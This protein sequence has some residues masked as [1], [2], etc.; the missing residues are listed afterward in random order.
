MTTTMPGFKVLP[1]IIPMTEPDEVAVPNKVIKFE[2]V[3]IARAE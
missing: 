3:V 1:W 2:A